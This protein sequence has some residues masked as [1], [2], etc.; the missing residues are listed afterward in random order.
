ME[1]ERKRDQRTRDDEGSAKR[2][3]SKK[4]KW[5]D[6]EPVGE[7][8]RISERMTEEREGWK[9]KNEGENKK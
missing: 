5:C 3:E 7:E 8:W 4:K 2:A 6:E 1:Q 9:G